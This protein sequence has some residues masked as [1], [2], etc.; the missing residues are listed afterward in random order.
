MLS[1]LLPVIGRQKGYL[2]VKISAPILSRDVCMELT[3]PVMSVDK[4]V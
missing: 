3:Q 1:A 4:Q 2:M